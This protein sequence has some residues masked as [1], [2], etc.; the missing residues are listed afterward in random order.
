MPAHAQKT[1]KIEND[2]VLTSWFTRRLIVAEVD[3]V[4]DPTP[5]LPHT[6]LSAALIFID[7]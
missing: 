6:E 4:F 7:G 1:R 3:L 5:A 2:V